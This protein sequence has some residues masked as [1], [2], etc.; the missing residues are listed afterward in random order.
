M[1]QNS[2]NV[3]IVS[4]IEVNPSGIFSS[5]VRSWGNSAHIPLPKRFLGKKAIVILEDQIRKR[6]KSTKEILEDQYG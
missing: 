5:E 2:F 6:Q 4:D 3:R 1:K